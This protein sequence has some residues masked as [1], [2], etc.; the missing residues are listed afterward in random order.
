MNA[1]D[2][3]ADTAV[4]VGMTRATWDAVTECC[5]KVLA[6]R[7]DSLPPAAFTSLGRPC[8]Y[9]RMSSGWAR[10]TKALK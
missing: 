5:E 1:A 10:G 6:S 3:D 7:E 2:E 4:P 8:V 9:K